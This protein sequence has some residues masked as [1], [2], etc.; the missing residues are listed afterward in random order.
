MPESDNFARNFETHFI[1]IILHI[2]MLIDASGV[3]V[4][5]HTTLDC[6][7]VTNPSVAFSFG[8]FPF[9]IFCPCSFLPSFLWRNKKWF[10]MG[11]RLGKKVEIIW[12]KISLK[13]CEW[14]SLNAAGSE[15][16]ASHSLLESS[17]FQFSAP[18][19]SFPPFSGK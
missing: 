9:P 14:Y 16:P 10:I 17:L 7:R 19:P 18:A 12:N 3:W 15:T 13:G 5:C 4:Q 8:E 1:T 2:I 6:P 11:G